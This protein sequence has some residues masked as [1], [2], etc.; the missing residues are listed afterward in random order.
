MCN[1]SIEYTGDKDE[2]IGRFRSTIKAQTNGQF[3]GDVTNGAFS[4]TAMGFNIFGNYIIKGD[5]IQVNITEKPFLL[6][7]SR[8]ES[9]VKRY[10]GL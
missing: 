10:L 3:E 6:S 8:I 4:L 2:L 7:C 1:F 5:L 9:E